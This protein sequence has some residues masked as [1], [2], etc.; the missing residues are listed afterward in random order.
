MQSFIL[1]LLSFFITVIYS[2]SHSPR[3]EVCNIPSIYASS[4]GEAD[5]SPAIASAFSRCAKDA[6]IVFSEGVNYNVFR[7]ISAKL[8]NVAIHVKGNIHLPQNVTLVQSLVKSKKGSTWF[9][10]SGPQIDYIGIADVNQGW[11]NSYG[12]PWYDANAAV[13][14]TGLPNRPHLMS[15]T[16][17]DGSVQ[18]F[19]SKKPI[20]WNV[21]LKGNN[22]TVSNPVIDAVSNSSSFPFNTD[23]FGVSGSNI[24]IF[25]MSVFNGDDAVAIGPGAHNVFVQGGTIGYQTH[26]LSIGSLK[27]SPNSPVN[28]TNIHFDNITVKDSIYAARFKSWVGGYG[29]AKNITWSNIRVENVSMPIFVTQTYYNQ[30]TSIAQLDGN[31]SVQMEDFTWTNFT[32][33]INSLNPGDGSCVSEPCWYNTG[34][35]DLKHTE[36]VIIECS[37]ERSCKN[38]ALK[39]I[40]MR[41]QGMDPASVICMKAMAASNPKLGF[42]CKNG[43]FAAS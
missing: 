20:G 31:S 3:V 17:T 2:Y 37:S 18:Y 15:F 21:S 7:P 28:V 12:Q 41:P 26:G 29:L 25:N 42:E 22:I 13:K 38:F 4:D 30:A 14:G 11:I 32:G 16:T 9:Q 34:L 33:T 39:G 27:G 23:A 35:A 19:K 36:A 1:F 6:T 40:D 43:T 8:D 5:D 10:F 24:R